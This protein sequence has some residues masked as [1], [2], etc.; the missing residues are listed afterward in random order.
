[1]TY[2]LDKIVKDMK[3]AIKVVAESDLKPIQKIVA[4]QANYY[5]MAFGR[6]PSIYDL[7]LMTGFSKKNVTNAI[8]FLKDE[9]WIDPREYSS[10]CCKWTDQINK[11]QSR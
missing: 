9:F 5:L 3:V 11:M 1:M 2:N 10:V 6:Y 4:N 7:C 8:A